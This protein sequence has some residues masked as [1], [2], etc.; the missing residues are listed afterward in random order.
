MILAVSISF[1]SPMWGGKAS[2]KP[3]QSQKPFGPWNLQESLA[4]T[5]CPGTQG[6]CGRLLVFGSMKAIL[7]GLD[8]TTGKGPPAHPFAWKKPS[9]TGRSH[10]PPGWKSICGHLF[11]PYPEGRCSSGQTWTDPF[12]V[13]ETEA[14]KIEAAHSS[15]KARRFSHD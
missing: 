9:V 1:S 8:S 3:M 2:K 5:H 15:H 10:M 12:T 11:L 14:G 6:L 4:N 13:R 7:W